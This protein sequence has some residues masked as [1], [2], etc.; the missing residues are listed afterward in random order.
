MGGS[1]RPWRPGTMTLDLDA[2]RE[3][4]LKALVTA[5]RANEPTRA[6]L[7]GVKGTALAAATAADRG[8]REAPTMP[9]IERYTGVL[10]R[11]LG[12]DS[13]RPAER[14]R[15][16]E[17]VLIVSG[18]WGVVAPP[19]PI[20]DYR[21]RMGVSLRGLGRLSTWWRGPLS[22]AVA[23]RVDGRPVW[24]L[25]PNEH[26]AAWAAPAGVVQRSVRFL[27]RGKDGA[28][29]AVSHRNKQLK[30]ALV[31]YLLS[32]PGASPDD[33]ARWED[34]SGFRYEPALDERREGLSILS[35]VQRD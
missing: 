20:P 8:V 25:L 21:L 32:H 1:G 27:E 23:E 10:Y 26:A 3:V 5:M 35:L 33:L 6:G 28:L 12:V 34:P 7:L 19:D 16:D 18:L 24:N 9:A 17:G 14:R 15:L 31:R 29:V 2:E 30:G 13:L 4:V 22:A 11:A